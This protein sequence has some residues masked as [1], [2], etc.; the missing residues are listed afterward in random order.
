MTPWKKVTPTDPPNWQWVIVAAS[1][2][3]Y[4]T[5]AMRHGPDKWVRESK[6]AVRGVTHWMPMPDLPGS[7]E[8]EATP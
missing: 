1:S 5:M 8:Q 2:E 3:R 7:A 6:F 4:S